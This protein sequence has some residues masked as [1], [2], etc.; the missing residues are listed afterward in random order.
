MEFRTMKPSRFAS[1]FLLASAF[2]YGSNASAWEANPSD[3]TVKAAVEE[4]Y[5]A[6][7]QVFVGDLKDMDN[8]WSHADDV[9]YHGPTGCIKQGWNAVRRDWVKQA[10][11]KLGGK[12]KPEKLT[13]IIGRDLAIVSNYEIGKNIGPD[14]KPIRVAIRATSTFRKEQGKWKMIGHH[15]DP[16]PYLSETN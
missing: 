13:F 10:N 11:L 6:L 16:L 4:F 8:V 7:N 12:V 5:S 1:C 2:M 3:K 9:T 14:R 15:A